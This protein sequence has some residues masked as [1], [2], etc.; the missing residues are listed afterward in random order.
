MNETSAAARRLAIGTA[1]AVAILAGGC[2]GRA[3]ASHPSMTP[4]STGG[5]PS[6]STSGSTAVV[7]APATETNPPGDIPDSQAFVL[8]APAGAPYTV[9]VP[10]GWA[11]TTSADGA[12]FTDKYNR[13]VIVVSKAE[14]TNPVHYAQSVELAS[15]R[16]GSPGFAGGTVTSVDR[17]AG[18]VVLISFQADSPVNPVTGKVVVEQVERYDYFRGGTEVT[19]TLAAPVGSDNVDPWRTITDSFRWR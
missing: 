16:A 4:S 19:V 7:T 18:H 1:V 14:P 12:T 3:P 17:S 5:I 15:I 13:I 8:F 2:S 11:T 10:E 9:S 6:V